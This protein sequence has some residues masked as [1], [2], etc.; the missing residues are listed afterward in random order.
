[1]NCYKYVSETLV[2]VKGGKFITQ[3]KESLFRKKNLYHGI[4]YHGKK[5]GVM[6][7]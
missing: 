1:M 2:S 6:F 5:W 3:T 4:G 7:D